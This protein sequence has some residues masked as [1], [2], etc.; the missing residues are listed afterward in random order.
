MKGDIPSPLITGP[1]ARTPTS[2]L[3]GL[4]PVGAA[5]ANLL[6][7]Y[8]VRVLAIDKSTE[9]FEQAARHR[10]RQRGA[11]HP[12][13]GRRARRRVRDRRDPPR[14]V[15]LAA[16]RTVRTHQ[17]RRH[18]R[19]A[20]DARHL[21]PA[22]A[23]ALLRSKLAQYPSVE[24]RLGVELESFVD[25]GRQRARAPE[26]RRRRAVAGAGALPRRRRR[27]E[28]AGAADCSGWNSRAAP[29]RRTG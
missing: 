7:R 5:L 1:R 14:R 28:L 6:G 18:H 12:A 24:V 26:G 2:L 29:T 8:G 9:I 13:D 22:R 19:R 21:L 4:G 20:S 16:V 3:V 15:P 23:R 17:Q 27:R 10:A 11:A 25:E